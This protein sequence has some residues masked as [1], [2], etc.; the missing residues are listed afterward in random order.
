M[1]N[2]PHYLAD[3]PA[4]TDE[5]ILTT[6]QRSKSAWRFWDGVANTLSVGLIGGLLAMAAMHP[7]WEVMRGVFLVI[8][9][10]FVVLLVVL[11]KAN[12]LRFNG[13][14]DLRPLSEQPTDCVEALTLTKT[15]SSA[16][17]WRDSVLNSG[18]QLYMFDLTH[19]RSLAQGDLNRASE[20]QLSQACRELHGNVA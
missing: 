14:T 20:R 9:L 16:C 4:L 17:A 3:A 5:L 11:A 19:M 12:R 13:V 7:S 10:G 6:H 2:V 15:S 1:N 8:F 18:R